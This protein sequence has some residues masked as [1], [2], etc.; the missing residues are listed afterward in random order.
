MKKLTFL[1]FFSVFS[2]AGI[3]KEID[4][5]IV[6]E[7][8]SSITIEEFYFGHHI[9]VVNIHNGPTV[10]LWG[11]DEESSISKDG[12]LTNYLISVGYGDIAEKPMV[13]RIK[14]SAKLNFNRKPADSIAFGENS[15]K[16]AL[17]NAGNGLKC[18]YISLNIAPK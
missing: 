14:S 7:V 8:A 13:F 16:I 6:Q 18:N 10:S 11:F 2:N 15:L 9:E 5:G 17:L 4:C 3:S 1:L 12:L